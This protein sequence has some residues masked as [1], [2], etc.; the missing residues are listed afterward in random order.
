MRGPIKGR[1]TV[2]QDKRPEPRPALGPETVGRSDKQ[3][4]GCISLS[5]P[6]GIAN[7]ETM[8]TWLDCRRILYVCVVLALGE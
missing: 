1:L 4:D 5:L 8:S 2:S 7:A 3:F 6:N